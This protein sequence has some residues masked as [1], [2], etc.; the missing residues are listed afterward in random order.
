MYQ[1]NLITTRVEV[2][3]MLVL[4]MKTSPEEDLHAVSETRNGVSYLISIFIRGYIE[5]ETLVPGISN[6]VA[7]THRLLYCDSRSC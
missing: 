4:K 5:K 7:V 2:V 1:A 6:S 3:A